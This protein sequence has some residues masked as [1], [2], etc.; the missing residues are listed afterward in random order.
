[1]ISKRNELHLAD[2]SGARK[3]TKFEASN[4]NLD[5]SRN[6]SRLRHSDVSAGGAGNF[7][8]SE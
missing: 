7:N 5:H 1:M 6:R 2:Y 4:I 3:S 8:A